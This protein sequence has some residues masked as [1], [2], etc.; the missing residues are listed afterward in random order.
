MED[1]NYYHKLLTEKFGGPPSVKQVDQYA[2]EDE[3]LAN[4]ILYNP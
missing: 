1:L 2:R 3:G 4:A